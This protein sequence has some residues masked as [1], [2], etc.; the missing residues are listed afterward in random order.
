MMADDDER[1]NWHLDKRVNLG[2]MLTTAMLFGAM[3]MSVNDLQ[4]Q[5][6]RNTNEV[7]H[8]REIIARVEVIS[9]QRLRD[10]KA[11]LDKID[12]KID[13]LLDRE[14]QRVPGN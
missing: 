13:R 9:A 11:Q 14:L 4:D 10:T 7:K 12:S 3:L 1:T 2:H 5:V 8:Q 6:I